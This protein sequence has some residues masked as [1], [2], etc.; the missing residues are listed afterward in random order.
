MVFAKF[1]VNGGADLDVDPDQ[2]TKCDQVFQHASGIVIR[3]CHDLS[4]GGC[5]N[6]SLMKP[7]IQHTTNLSVLR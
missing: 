4:N 6:L 2:Q 7:V 1:V 3:G 5:P